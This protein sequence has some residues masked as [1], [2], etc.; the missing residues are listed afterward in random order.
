MVYILSNISCPDLLDISSTKK[1]LAQKSE[2]VYTLCL[3]QDP[4]A[5]P[6]R[7]FPALT[8]PLMH[9]PAKKNR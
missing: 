2:V 3:Q 6:D 7:L 1:Y 8:A 4:P 9:H 5:L